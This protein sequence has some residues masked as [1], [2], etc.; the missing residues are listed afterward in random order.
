MTQES[1]LKPFALGDV[2]DLSWIG[3]SETGVAGLFEALRDGWES[4]NLFQDLATRP[5]V[6]VPGV[7]D[8]RE[9]YTSIRQ[10]ELDDHPAVSHVLTPNT[11]FASKG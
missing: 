5:H 7:S 4:E 10:F 11:A 3:E 9:V 8:Y 1:T 2:F 6:F